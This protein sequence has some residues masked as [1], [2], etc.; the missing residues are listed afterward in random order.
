M[1]LESKVL[2]SNLDSVIHLLMFLFQ[3]NISRVGPHLLK[4]EFQHIRE[5]EC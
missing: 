3:L 2:S 4:L 5:D 1:I